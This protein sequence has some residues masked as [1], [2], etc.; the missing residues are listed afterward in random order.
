VAAGFPVEVLN[1][2][3]LLDSQILE[4]ARVQLIA[5]Y[6][7]FTKGDHYSALGHIRRAL[8]RRRELSPRDESFL[9]TLREAAEF[10][11]GL[12]DAETYRQRLAARSRTLEGL[13]A[14]EARQDAL[15]HQYL[16]EKDGHFR[17][18]ILE[19]LRAVTAEILGHPDAH[20]GVKLDARLL[21]LFIEGM[22]SNIQTDETL[23]QAEIREFLYPSDTKSATENLQNARRNQLQWERRADEA[24]R[25]AYDFRHPVLIVQALIITLYVQTGRLFE[26]RMEAINGHQAYAVPAPA[27]TSIERLF[28]EAY[29]LSRLSGLV[30]ARLTLD[31]LRVRFLEIKGDLDGARTAAEK[32]FPEADAMGFNAIAEEAREALENR[33]LLMRYEQDIAKSDLLHRDQLQATQTDEQL[34]RL[35][36]QMVKIIGSPPAH[37]KK[38]LG[39]MRSLRF[40]AQERCGWCRHLQ[41][42]ENLTQTTDPATAFS[43]SP[44]RRVICEKF[45]HVSGGESVDVI[46]IVEDFKRDFCHSCSARDPRGS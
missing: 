34:S 40:I 21:L 46:A 13:E 38:L 14:L 23:F 25:E 42:Q 29:R 39:Y 33:T 5:G 37:P 32:L 30:E 45:N 27:K 12:V 15:H 26:K 20:R 44:M 43:V 9:V 18:A 16:G 19:Q 6:A 28:T 3:R 36:Q 10:H 35:T 1:L 17:A 31:K 22:Q 11:V 41:L 2:I 4:T 7:E 8:A 24:L